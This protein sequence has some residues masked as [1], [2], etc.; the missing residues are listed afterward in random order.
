MPSDETTGPDRAAPNR[1]KCIG[2][3]TEAGRKRALCGR[4]DRP[5]ARAL[6]ALA[7]CW[8]ALA[9]CGSDDDKVPSACTEGPDAFRAALHAAPRPV[10]LDGARLSDC[11]SAT[12]APEN[13]QL[14]GGTFVETAAR[15]AEGAR[16]QPEGRA[17]VELGYLVAA[18][19]RGS[20]QTQGVAAELLRR[21][22][23]EV[24]TVDTHSRAFRRG[25][26]AGGRSG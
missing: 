25:E 23:Q 1:T 11:L 18:A 3:A 2:S 20:A 9:G 24:R 19:R 26:R 6:L 4:Y 16:R 7:S 22:D 13:L 21:L 8:L 17:A 5:M 10:R 12:S 15:L 14:V